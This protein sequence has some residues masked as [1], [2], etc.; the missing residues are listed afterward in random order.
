MNLAE[1]VREVS[2]RRGAPR[3]HTER[4]I[5]AFLGGIE[6]A[7]SDGEEVELRRF[8]SFRIRERRRLEMRH[9]G[10]GERIT[11]PARILPVFRPAEAL[12]RAVR[13]GTT[14]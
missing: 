4:I 12:R 11:V 14:G 13:E 1:I 8:G 9:P 3:A 5:K 7:L 10:T 6:R 2:A